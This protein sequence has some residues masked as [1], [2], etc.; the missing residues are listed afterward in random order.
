ML[1]THESNQ[2]YKQLLR[3][4]ARPQEPFLLKALAAMRRLH[5]FNWFV[6]AVSLFALAMAWSSR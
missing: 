5:A 6:F 3:P 2:L 4:G 1:S